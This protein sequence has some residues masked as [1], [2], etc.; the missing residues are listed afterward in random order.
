MTMSSPRTH[1]ACPRRC[2]PPAPIEVLPLSGVTHM[3]PQEVVA[4]NLLLRE[5]T[6]FARHLQSEVSTDS[7]RRVTVQ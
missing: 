7:G 3:T 2:W 1:C 5:L 6:F 4:R